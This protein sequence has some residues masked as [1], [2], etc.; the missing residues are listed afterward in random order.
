MA[1]YRNVML[2]PEKFNKNQIRFY[3]ILVPMALFMLLP[4]MFII[5][6]ALK[7]MD[8]LFAYPPRFYTLRPTL[9]NFKRLFIFSDSF[10]QP[11][12]HYIFNSIVSSA[13]VVMLSLIF[14]TCAGYVLSK[15]NFRLKNIVLKINTLSL[16]FVGTAVQIPRYLV[17]SN[18][19]IM[20]TF[21]AHIIPMVAMPIGLFLIKQ[22]IDQMPT[23]LIEAAKIDGASDYYII[24]HI[25]MPL[26][27]PALATIG[28]LAFQASWN[29]DEASKIY[30]ERDGLK[31]MAYIVNTIT[32]GTASSPIGS[33]MSA[34]GSLIMF[35]PNLILFIFMQSRV[36][37]TMAHSGIK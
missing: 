16:M 1:N 10:N 8:E 4:I 37:N 33:G 9:M 34:A 19:K 31:N 3:I 22:F 25:V 36:M 14:S 21:S 35:L 24:L 27:K 13:I 32:S 17:I 5:F 20:D 12:S 30:I 7:P 11:M 15:K 26:V 23:E 2:N 29:S 6:N 28:I 18:L